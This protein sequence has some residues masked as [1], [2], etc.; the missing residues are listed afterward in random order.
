MRCVRCRALRWIE[1]WRETE[2][3]TLSIVL[4]PCG[5]VI[6]RSARLEWRQSSPV[7]RDLVLT[8]LGAMAP[9][10]TFSSGS[11]GARAGEPI[12]QL[13]VYS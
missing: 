11:S 2:H 7:D 4:G 9:G 8:S 12:E 10:P 5:H 1:D 13:T 6:E 3:E